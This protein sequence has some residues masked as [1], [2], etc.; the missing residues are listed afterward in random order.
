MR[1]SIPS[2]SALAECLGDYSKGE[3]NGQGRQLRVVH[4]SK[5]EARRGLG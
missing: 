1:E 2:I 4:L 3:V 5:R